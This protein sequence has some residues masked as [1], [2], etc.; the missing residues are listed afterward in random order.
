MSERIKELLVELKHEL[1]LM[2]IDSLEELRAD[3][4]RQL[5]TKK[6]P[7]WIC[8]FCGYIVDRVIVAKAGGA[9]V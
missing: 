6:V 2:D 1:N 3:W 9:A 7:E 4:M 5:K 8:D